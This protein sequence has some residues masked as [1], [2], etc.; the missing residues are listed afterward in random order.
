MKNFRILIGSLILGFIVSLFMLVCTGQVYFPIIG[1]MVRTSNKMVKGISLLLLY[2]LAFILPLTTVF[3]LTY[4]GVSSEK[5]GLFFKKHV[6]EVKLIF[7]FLFLIFGI[8][9]FII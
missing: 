6:P 9:N 3:I 2:D 5:A 7:F 1:Y 4:F 8:I